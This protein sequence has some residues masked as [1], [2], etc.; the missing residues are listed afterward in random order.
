MHKSHQKESL[1]KPP[2]PPWGALAAA[3]PK[4]NPGEKEDILRGRGLSVVQGRALG[5]CPASST[6]RGSPQGR[7]V[8]SAHADLQI[9]VLTQGLV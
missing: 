9:F 2:A 7:A 5:L 6:A 4:Y 3:N 8:R 1:M